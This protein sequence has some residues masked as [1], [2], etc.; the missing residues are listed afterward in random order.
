MKWKF[1]FGFCWGKDGLLDFSKH[2]GKN[3]EKVE[4]HSSVF[5]EKNKNEV[6][7]TK[8]A[9]GKYVFFLALYL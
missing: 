2:E 7:K 1:E 5:K 6:K 4:G 9:K 3:L 8:K